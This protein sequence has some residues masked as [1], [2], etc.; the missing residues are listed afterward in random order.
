MYFNYEGGL[1]REPLNLSDTDENRE[2]AKGLAAT[3]KHE[4]N[5]D[6]FDYARYFP[7]SKRLEENTLQYWVK[8]WLEIKKGKVSPATLKGYDRWCRN[9]IIP[10]FGSRQA[11][12]IDAIEVDLWITNDLLKLS[13]K[14]IKDI[15]SCLRQIYVMYRKR[16]HSAANPTD[17]I[18]VDLPD[19]DEPDAFN[20]DEIEKI[21][22]THTKQPGELNA[23]TFAMWTGPRPSEF[24]SLGWDDVNLR[25]GEV[26][27]CRSVVLGTYKATK[28]KRSKRWVDLLVP[29]L[30][31]LR[32]QHELTGHLQAIEIEV[33][34]RDNRTIKKELFRPVF[35]CT[36]TDK[37]YL[38]VKHF[39]RSFFI[40]HLEKAEVRHRCVSICRHSFAS[41]MLS[42]GVMPIDWICEQMGH[43]SDAMLRRK[44]GKYFKK[45]R[46]INPADLANQAFGFTS[47][48]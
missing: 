33:L 18:K 31:A 16:N 10:K 32:R 44:Y 27:F 21:L 47:V 39:N 6:V 22:Q 42:T 20:L 43:T 17:G 5:A 40:K 19:D 11:E 37:P 1:C 12:Q 25:T 13:S 9:Y 28:T 34:Q 8:L 14:S 45:Q 15:I 41:Q 7:E 30:D 26:V 36:N 24:L 29:A 2:Y 3:I 35:I 48:S 4:I 38:D 46:K 23:V